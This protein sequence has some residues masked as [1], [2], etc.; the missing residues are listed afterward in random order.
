LTGKTDDIIH[1]RISMKSGKAH[2]PLA[3]RKELGTTEPGYILDAKTVLLCNPAIS[4]QDLLRSIELLLEH[5]K[6]KTKVEI[7]EGQN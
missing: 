5:I 1:G 7:N 4:V 6:L 2:I 3:V